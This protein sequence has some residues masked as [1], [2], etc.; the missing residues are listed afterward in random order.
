MGLMIN[1]LVAVAQIATKAKTTESSSKVV[2]SVFDRMANEV[3][4][5]NIFGK[6]KL[7]KELR[8]K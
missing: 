3:Y 5:K 7:C 6:R 4:P 2:S 8:K 1:M